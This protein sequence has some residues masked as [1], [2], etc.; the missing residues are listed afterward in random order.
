MS[1]P[2]QV[3]LSETDLAAGKAPSPAYR[4]SDE[5]VELWEVTV[6]GLLAEA[7]RDSGDRPALCSGSD[8][9]RWTYAELDAAA[10]LV[11]GALAGLLDPGDRLAAWAAGL[12]EWVL[13]QFGA[14]RA[15]VVLVPLNPVY[16][17][18]ELSYALRQSRA[19][20]VFHGRAHAGRSLADVIA[21]VRGDC[22]ELEHVLELEPL[23]DWAAAGPA[24]P[25]PE[26]APEAPV[27]IQYT[28]GTTGRPKGA[29]L[30]HRG[31]VN[32]ARLAA[33][34]C[35]VAPGGVWLNP[36]P[37]FHTGGCVFNALGALANRGLH[38]LMPTWDAGAALDLAEREGVTFLC[39][40]P[41]M[42]IGMIE[43]PSYTPARVATLRNVACGGT[44]IPPE[45]VRRFE[46]ALEI[47]YTMIFG[48][49]EAG[50]TVCGTHPRDSPEDKS[51]TI[52]QPL[53]H[54][55][56]MI[57]DVDTGEVV[58]YDTPGEICLRGFGR[59]L[60]YFE[61][62]DETA[63]AIDPDG[64]LH[65]GD[66]G[67][68]DERGYLKITGRLKEIIRRGG[69]TISP[70]AIEDLLFGSPG[71]AEV[72]VVGVPDERYGEQVAAFVL[73]SPDASPDL[74]HLREVCA[75][76][77]SPH[78]VP[79]FWAVLDEFPRTPSGKVRKFV[80]RDEFVAGKHPVV[81]L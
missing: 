16:R 44:T 68:L 38:V 12:P 31:I 73:R 17:A 79:R 56:V 15:G 45:L 30:T 70:R 49:T 63:S 25:L 58:G 46:V 8:D 7:A 64:W 37:L 66:L 36:L 19:R 55:E 76:H 62:P 48:Q 22:P 4:P 9:R 18:G 75:E 77:L 14:A 47:D 59:M 33:D 11:A 28:S 5:S 61:L 69:E 71:V 78:K 21:E 80:L 32:N 54:T 81:R 20:A 57:V 35:G 65:T 23:L 40:V 53:P 26:V 2:G 74:A 50:P 51:S 67:Q 60:G 13:L 43:H 10:E 41:T 39:A 1:V 27:M 42:L 52:G 24:K 72:A 6:G 34:R 29:V 3:S